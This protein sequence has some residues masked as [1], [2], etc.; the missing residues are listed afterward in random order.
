MIQQVKCQI[1]G[2]NPC[3]VPHDLDEIDLSSYDTQGAV[4]NSL[5]YA[6]GATN[7]KVDGLTV[8]PPIGS[9]V[10]FE[11]HD[12]AYKLTTGTN[13][14]NLTLLNGLEK[15]VE[16][17]EVFYIEPVID[18]SD[19]LLAV[20]DWES[21]PEISRNEYTLDN[22][23]DF[24]FSNAANQFYD[25][26]QYLSSWQYG[27]QRLL[28][29]F[30]IQNDR[31]LKFLR[32]A[33]KDGATWNTFYV[34]KFVEGET[35]VIYPDNNVSVLTESVLYMLRDKMMRDVEDVYNNLKY[36]DADNP[37]RTICGPLKTIIKKTFYSAGIKSANVL[38]DS[39]G[40]F[41]YETHYDWLYTFDE[42]WF[43][44]PIWKQNDV[45]GSPILSWLEAMMKRFLAAVVLHFEGNTAYVY[46]RSKR[47]TDVHH[48]VLG[49]DSFVGQNNKDKVKI[50]SW[51][52]YSENGV[53]AKSTYTYWNGEQIQSGF[54]VDGSGFHHVTGFPVERQVQVEGARSMYLEAEEEDKIE[55][56]GGSE[57]TVKD[58]ESTEFWWVKDRYKVVPDLQENVREFTPFAKNAGSEVELEF[59]ECLKFKMWY[60]DIFV[61]CA[62]SSFV[63]LSNLGSLGQTITGYRTVGP[64]YGT[65]L[66]VSRHNGIAVVDLVPVSWHPQTGTRCA[67]YTDRINTDNEALKF[68]TLD[69][70]S[71]DEFGTTH[72]LWLD[73]IIYTVN[74]TGSGGVL[75]VGAGFIKAR[76]EETD[77]V[78]TRLVVCVGQKEVGDQDTLDRYIIDMDT[79]AGPI[80]DYF[81][82]SIGSFFGDDDLVEYTGVS[83]STIEGTNPKGIST[84]S[85]PME[86]GTCVNS[87]V[88]NPWADDKGYFST[89]VY[90]DYIIKVN[91]FGPTNRREI[92]FSGIPILSTMKGLHV[93]PD[94]SVTN[95]Q[96]VFFVADDKIYKCYGSSFS[97]LSV[98]AGGGANPFP[99]LYGADV[100]T[101]VT[102][103][104]PYSVWKMYDN[105]IVICDAAEQKV[106]I[107]NLDTGMLYTL[108]DSTIT[109]LPSQVCAE[110][111][112][113]AW[114]ISASPSQGNT[115]S[116]YVNFDYIA[117]RYMFG[118][119]GKRRRVFT[120]RVLASSF[121]QRPK[122]Y[123]VVRLDS[124]L[125]VGSGG[126]HVDCWITSI[127]YNFERK[128]YFLE[129]LESN[130]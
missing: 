73:D 48:D 93:H 109:E 84:E 130:V 40:Y 126:G 57:Y 56:V 50:S 101:D 118:Y 113:S 28:S 119:Y 90:S 96:Y 62:E 83:K 4:N 24:V 44:T 8:A 123:D 5:G 79:S 55:V 21:T 46:F 63:Q 89:A 31:S 98:I 71:A 41:A 102:L 85:H 42:I 30:D 107:V 38:F 106:A 88:L 128:E 47:N 94:E 52:H 15:R 58:Y 22:Q 20:S 17:D 75:H 59:G 66:S 78:A 25:R 37:T 33:L 54:H 51:D 115:W 68:S 124:S 39:A 53:F 77:E 103:D 18:V 116:F 70:P 92:V 65:G 95:G 104:D 34:G 43:N 127:R 13:S 108:T 111:F 23:M 60:P 61:A 129:L 82:F 10:R 81:G 35:S 14:T 26:L 12:W 1:T 76:N 11:G 16:D 2:F 36:T 32:I 29:D 74:N 72:G 64:F 69:V 91:L 80:Q 3:W 6:V 19:D 45:D 120:G 100:A 122:M 7:I 110:D 87:D 97:N 67:F 99:S 86:F 121:S 105:K 125:F 49:Q 112:M 114:I 9:V 117:S 27:Q